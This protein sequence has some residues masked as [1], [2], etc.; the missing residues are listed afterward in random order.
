MIEF[1]STNMPP[2]DALSEAFLKLVDG[3]VSMDFSIA[4]ISTDDKANK[5]YHETRAALVD[6]LNIAI[7][8]ERHVTT[9]IKFLPKRQFL[10]GFKPQEG[11]CF[12]VN[13]KIHKQIVCGGRL[14]EITE[15]CLLVN[16]LQFMLA[17]ADDY[18][19]WAY[20][21]PCVC[22]TP[23]TLSQKALTLRTIL[24][25]EEDPPDAKP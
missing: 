11:L 7:V 25:I 17:Q 13:K 12:L 20:V 1:D 21:P 10:F 3:A 9:R 2:N 15:K 5:Y 24:Y 6:V 4:P 23:C 8:Y 18:R 14:A 16:S 19:Y 22:T